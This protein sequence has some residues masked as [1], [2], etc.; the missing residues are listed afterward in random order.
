[1]S[2][3]K[4]TLTLTYTPLAGGDG[5]S[6]WIRLE[7]EKPEDATLSVADVAA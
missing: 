7:Q 3:E 1:M 2:A 5:E 4:Q 6:R